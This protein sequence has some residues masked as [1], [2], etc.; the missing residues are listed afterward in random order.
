MKKFFALSCIGLVAFASSGAHG[1]MNPPNATSSGLAVQNRSYVL[2]DHGTE[3][4]VLPSSRG[5]VTLVAGHTVHKMARAA[6]AEPFS[7][8]TVGVVYNHSLKAYGTITGEIGFKLKS[9][10]SLVTA[11]IPAGLAPT[12]VLNQ[13]VYLVST[14]T[15]GEFV[16]V[17]K[18]LQGNPHLEWV[19]AIVGYGSLR[20]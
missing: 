15:P 19:E 6:A 2:H 16:N 17:Y 18:A 9:G 3:L 12:P 20:P 11:N 1:Q 4:E 14:S 13:E 7:R 5:V 10:S 8:A